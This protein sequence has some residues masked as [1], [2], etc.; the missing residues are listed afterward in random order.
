ME[1]FG[2]INTVLAEQFPEWSGLSVTP[3]RQQG[4]DNRTFRLGDELAVRLPSHERYA[5]GIVKEDLP[6]RTNAK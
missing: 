3:V 6:W 4:N 5:A 2:N 1:D